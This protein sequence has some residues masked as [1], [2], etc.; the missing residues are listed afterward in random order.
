MAGS[1]LSKSCKNSLLIILKA[2]SNK[3]NKNFTAKYTII[4][5]LVVLGKRSEGKISMA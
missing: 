3:A 4:H 2:L 5:E 1:S